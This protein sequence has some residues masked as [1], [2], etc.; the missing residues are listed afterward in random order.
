M[1][2]LNPIK[3]QGNWKEGYSI[4]LHTISSE[5]LGIDERGYEQYDTKRSQLGQLL[6]DLKYKQ[7]KTATSKI[8][9]LISPFLKSWDIQNKI[10]AIIPIPP[11]NKHRKIQ[12]VYEISQS[13]SL[14]LDVPIY[15]DFLENTRITESKNQKNGISGSII[16]K[17]EF[18][19]SNNNVLLID[20][21]YQSGMTIN[22]S[23]KTLRED[24]NINDIY[25]LTM[26]KT[27]R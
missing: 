24:S 18:V 22:E 20:D 19:I 5:F 25:I 4:D 17:K 12:P 7:D 6:Y 2:K 8:I 16:A 13:I 3:L 27:R 14:I 1:L 23:V 26:T 10:D 21:L 9:T 15:H 11:S